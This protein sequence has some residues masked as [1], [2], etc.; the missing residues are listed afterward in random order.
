[1]PQPPI[2]IDEMLRSYASAVAAK[3]AEA[4]MRLYDP[5]VRVFDAWDNWIYEGAVA[6]QTVVRNWFDS[7][8]EETVRVTFDDTQS[9]G[10]QELAIVSAIVTY[11]GLSAQG[12][13]LRSLQNR[14]TWAVRLSD[15]GPRIIHEHTSAPI[16]FSD[17]KA[18]LKR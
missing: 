11:A 4:L 12:Q 10:G 17:M 3:D 14:I 9:S 15:P 1:M 13:V 2:A 7:L 6:W 8:G 16:G 18:I 5:H